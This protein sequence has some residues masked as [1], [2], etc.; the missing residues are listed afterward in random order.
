[1]VGGTLATVRIVRSRLRP[2]LFRTQLE[3]E[4]AT[5]ITTFGC[6][7]LTA[8]FEEKTGRGCGRQVGGRASINLPSRDVGSRMWG[9]ANH[10]A[11]LHYQILS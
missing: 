1:M 10:K 6:S 5:L 11:F 2:V 4:Q 3:K 8:C 7:R 9:G